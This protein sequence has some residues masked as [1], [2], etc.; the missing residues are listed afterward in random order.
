MQPFTLSQN[1]SILLQ[2]DYL[3]LGA[4]VSIVE[5]LVGKVDSWEELSVLKVMIIAVS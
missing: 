2:I 4:S 3:G 5:P 1:D